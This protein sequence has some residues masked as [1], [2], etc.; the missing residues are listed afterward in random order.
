MGEE[1]SL[2]RVPALDQLPNSGEE[3]GVPESRKL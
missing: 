3:L 2:D 1:I